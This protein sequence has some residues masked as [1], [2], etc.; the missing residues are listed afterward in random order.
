LNVLE[1]ETFGVATKEEILEYPCR[2]ER[3]RQLYNQ[4]LGRRDKAA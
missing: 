1:K 2:Q 3:I 4:L